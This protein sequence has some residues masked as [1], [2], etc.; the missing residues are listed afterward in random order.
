[1]PEV[2]DHSD[3][4]EPLGET[5]METIPDSLMFTWESQRDQ[6]PRFGPPG[7]TRMYVN[8]FDDGLEPLRDSDDPP[9]S[10]YLFRDSIGL[11]RGIAYRYGSGLELEERGNVSVWV[12]P[13]RRRQK[14]GTRLVAAVVADWK[15]DFRAQ[16]YS[17]TG[18]LFMESLD[19]G[20]R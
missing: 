13:A 2:I 7:L 4:G 9:V 3:G 20:P 10:V 19:L 11:L 5:M 12:D 15:P 8:S 17:E 1:M 6:F 14:I 18:R 16:R